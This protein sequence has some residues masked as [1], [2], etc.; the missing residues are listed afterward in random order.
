MLFNSIDFL[1]FFPSVVIIYFFVPRKMRYV[2]LLVA[3][4]FFYMSWNPKYALLIG[5]STVI[6]YVSGLIIEKCNQ[7]EESFKKLY[8]KI[9]VVG[10]VVSNLLILGIF[11]YANFILI[12][13]SVILSSL[14]FEIVERRLD[15]LLPIG[16]SF[17]IF[18]ALSYTLDVSKEKIKAERNILRYGLFVSFFP[19][20]VAGPIE[21]SENLLSQV[22]NVEKIN[23]WNYE[24]IC[25]GLLLMF[26]GLFQKLVI[27]DRAAIIVEEVY[28]HYSFYGLFEI[29]VATILFAF[30]IYCDFCGYSNIARGSAQI[31]GFRLVQNFRQPYL[32]DNIK[33]FWRRWHIS[34]TTWFTDY[35]YIPL[36]GNRKGL[37][38]KYW[39]IIVV[40]SVSGLWHGASWNFVAWGML[41]AFYQIAEDLYGKIKKRFFARFCKR[42]ISLSTKI[43]KIILTF[44]FVN[45]AWIFFASNG[46]YDAIKIIK[47]MFTVRQTT[48][49]R[50]GLD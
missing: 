44:F 16:I 49:F 32:A 19:Q 8:K 26:W 20:L 43:R 27:A 37:L 38:R 18:Q 31:M 35:L 24:R 28:G 3:S 29:M 47:Q 14:G 9:C 36:G 50:G 48:D 7:S 41:H 5:I 45:F 46:F 40:F 22:Q 39:N 34:L 11:K 23:V 1:F 33:E 13:V 42:E 10:C 30:Q 12:N 21:R 17:Y 2:W 6:T 15:L 4:Y 25:N